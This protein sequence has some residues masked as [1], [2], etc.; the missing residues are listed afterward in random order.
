M[1][2]EQ[3]IQL[4][5]EREE[6]QQEWGKEEFRRKLQQQKSKRDYSRSAGGK[7]IHRSF[8]EEILDQARETLDP[9]LDP[10]CV[11]PRAESL[12]RI[13]TSMMD[14]PLYDRIESEEDGSN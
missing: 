6:K 5:I 1:T 14:L 11:L 9:Y 2:E 10:N 8:Y 4:Q 7:V 3:L 13:L 12:H